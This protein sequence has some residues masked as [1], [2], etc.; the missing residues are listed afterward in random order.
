[1]STTD[2]SPGHA[3]KQQKARPEKPNEQQYKEDLAEAEREHAEAQRKFVRLGA[4][5]HGGYRPTIWSK[6]S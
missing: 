1:M 4:I 5:L 6:T 3:D 2:A